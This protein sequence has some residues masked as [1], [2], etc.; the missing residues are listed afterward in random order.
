MTLNFTNTVV[1]QRGRLVRLTSEVDNEII[2]DETARMERA[3]LKNALLNLV[4][5][6]SEFSEIDHTISE[7]DS[8]TK[9]NVAAKFKQGKF[10]YAAC[11]GCG[12]FFF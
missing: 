12:G 4:D 8:N 7:L 6:L 10:T 1:M 9:K 5:E 2:I 3:R 11:G